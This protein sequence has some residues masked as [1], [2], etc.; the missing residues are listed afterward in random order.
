MIFDCKMF[1]VTNWVAHLNR[2][3][4]PGRTPSHETL[5]VSTQEALEISLFFGHPPSLVS[6]HFS[7]PRV[8]TK[9]RKHYEGRRPSPQDHSILTLYRPLKRRLVRRLLS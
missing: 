2:E 9:S 5:S 8:V 1:D 4:G 7:L 3:D 6:D